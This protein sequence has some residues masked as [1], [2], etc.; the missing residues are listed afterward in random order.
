MLLPSLRVHLVRRAFSLVE[1]V[2][3]LAIFAFVAVALIGLF[4]VGLRTNRESVD[5]FLA[6]NIAQS[7]LAARRATPTLSL[8]GGFPL[9]TLDRSTSVPATD[10]LYLTVGGTLT[11]A[12]QARFGLIYRVAAPA[13]RENFAR[14]YL[15]LY[16]PANAKFSSA[17][18]RY[19][20]VSSLPVK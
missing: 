3:A 19:E 6:A 4:S 1:V 8:G 20:A 2:L 16:W 14:I 15:C 12:E 7:L 5:E 11:N 9:E 17:L 10:P 18:G 13:G